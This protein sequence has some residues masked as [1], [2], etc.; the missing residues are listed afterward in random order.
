MQ[1]RGLLYFADFQVIFEGRCRHIKKDFRHYAQLRLPQVS[2]VRR[3]HIL[4]AYGGPDVLAHD[5]RNCN[6]T[7]LQVHDEL[8]FQEQEL[9]RHPLQTRT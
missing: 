2:D 1:P 3:K 5:R 4:P 8:F 9:L 6:S 7:H